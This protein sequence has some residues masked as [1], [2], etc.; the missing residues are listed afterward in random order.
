MKSVLTKKKMYYWII[1]IMVILFF[2]AILF[3]RF[4]R[5]MNLL[6]RNYD[7]YQKVNGIKEYDKYHKK[8][9]SAIKIPIITY[10]RIVPHDIKEK[11]YPKNEWVNDADVVSEQL[12]YLNDNGWKSID[13]DEFYCWYNKECK[14]DEK[15]YVLTIDDGDYEA[16][17]VVLPMLKKYNIKATMFAI[18]SKIPEVTDKYDETK[19]K[20]LGFDIIQKLRKEDS[21][22]QIESHSYNMHYK[23]ENGNAIMEDLTIQEMEEDLK[24]SDEL[25]FRYFAYPY[26]YYNTEMLNVVA[27]D[28]QVKMAFKFKNGTYATRADNRYE[29]SRIKITSLT[30]MDEFKA[31]FD[32]S[33]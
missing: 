10:H 17:Y 22:L 27:N 14:F 31:W 1:V 19:R 3:D 28:P 4:P 32:Y 6:Y 9:V 21:L 12:K 26:G 33:K 16:Y 8:P 18:G 7:Y 11:D 30:T 20:K 5:F 25:G 29:I 23:N 24:K 2:V 13:L 15:T